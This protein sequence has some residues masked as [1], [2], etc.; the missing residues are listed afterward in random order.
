MK[1]TVV[2]A[3][4][5]LLLLCVLTAQVFAAVPDLNRTGSISI[6]MTYRGEVVPGGSLTLY[7]VAEIQKKNSADYSYALLEAYAASGVSLENLNDSALAKTLADYT[8]ANGIAGTKLQ[9]D[10]EG[11]I[12][13]PELQL[14]LYLLVQEDAAEGYAKVAPF[15]VSVP[16]M[17]NGVYVYDVDGSPKLSLELAPTDPPPETTQP[18][19]L[20]QT[21]QIQWPIPVLTVGGLLLITLGAYLC[22]NAK[23]K[24][25]EA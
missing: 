20:P 10:A 1:R 24:S 12:S 15:L 3:L 19:K 22:T 25:D 5:I 7:R 18:P 16:A 2:S 11:K 14:G 9:I 6:T 17:E 23:K 8:A 4:S 13:F 21:G